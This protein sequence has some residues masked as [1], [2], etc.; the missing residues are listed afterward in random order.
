M[1][2]KAPHH[3]RELDRYTGAVRE[4]MH[5]IPPN[6]LLLPRLTRH[7]IIM[8]RATDH[9]KYPAITW[10][11]PIFASAFAHLTDKDSLANQLYATTPLQGCTSLVSELVHEFA[12]K[13]AQL[14]KDAEILQAYAKGRPT[15]PISCP[16]ECILLRTGAV[17][18]TL[19]SLDEIYLWL[20][21]PLDDEQLNEQSITLTDAAFDTVK[22]NV[23]IWQQTHSHPVILHMT[24]TAS[25]GTELRKKGEKLTPLPR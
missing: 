15:G 14:G 19:T 20:T 18:F 16:Q 25:S 6:S 11:Q 1:E 13:A 17:S 24:V 9:Q 12:K 8:G 7:L 10:L 4:T 5:K 21:I 3:A 2:I 22:H 23:G